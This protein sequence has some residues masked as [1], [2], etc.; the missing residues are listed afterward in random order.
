MVHCAGELSLNQA[1]KKT[2]LARTTLKE[3]FLQL[4]NDGMVVRSYQRKGRGRPALV[5][6]LTEKGQ[7]QF[8]RND[9]PILNKLLA[10]LQKN[11]LA[12]HIN[13]FFEEYWQEKLVEAQDRLESKSFNSERERVDYINRYLEEL[14]FMPRVRMEDA[15][16]VIV[17]E[18]NCPF[19]N[20]V[21]KTHKP[22]EMEK[23]F[24]KRLFNG[25]IERISY[26]PEGDAA[27]TYKI[28][29]S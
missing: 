21:K 12:D 20:S 28:N 24:L 14:G 22:C 1:I 23:Q 9:G 8:P 2:H 25:E 13:T 7:S 18:C 15:D 5:Y 4:E 6:K 29:L 3:H 16:T 10:Y 27:C 26:M 19:S 11:E 17:R